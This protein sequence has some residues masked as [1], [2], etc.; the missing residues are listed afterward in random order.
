[1]M[2]IPL[3][4]PAMF[5]TMDIIEVYDAPA[6]LFGPSCSNHEIQLSS[7]RSSA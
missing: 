1:V 4:T 6:I 3:A 2:L 7:G 5:R